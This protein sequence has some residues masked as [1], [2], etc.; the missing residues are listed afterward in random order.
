[1]RPL[2]SEE[3]RIIEINR[4]LEATQSTCVCG[5]ID[6]LFIVEELKAEKK[7]LVESILKEKL[8]RTPVQ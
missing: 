4:R 3:E 5:S 7:S 6:E 8:K 1:M 2:T